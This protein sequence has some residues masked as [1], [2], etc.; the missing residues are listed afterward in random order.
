[1]IEETARIDSQLLCLVDGLTDDY[2]YWHGELPEALRKD[3][4]VLYVP[5][6]RNFQVELL[7]HPA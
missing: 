5:N 1:M 3:K 7:S 2:E 4:A 6:L